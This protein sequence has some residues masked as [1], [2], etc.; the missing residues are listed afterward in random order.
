MPLAIVDVV[1]VS[2]L[3]RAVVHGDS[4]HG[5][6]TVAGGHGFIGADGI[7]GSQ[8]ARQRTQAR[9]GTRPGAADAPHGQIR[10]F[11]GSPV[12]HHRHDP[13]RTALMSRYN[14]LWVAVIVAL[15][16]F[17]RS[18]TGFDLGVDDTT[19]TAIVGAIGAFLVWLIPNREPG[20]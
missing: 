1:D 14:K 9:S 3:P 11:L 7:L 18:Y 13:E 5:A 16:A 19:A 10:R 15:F 8:Q 12:R 20:K 4:H 6:G 17:I 2:V